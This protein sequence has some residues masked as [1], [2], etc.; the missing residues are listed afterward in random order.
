M[1]AN[2]IRVLGVDPASAGATGYA[3]IDG[4]GA[5]CAA[6]HYG[7]LPAARN[8]TNNMPARLRQIYTETASLIEK[9]Q[10][11]QVALEAIFAA[12][13]VRTALRLAEVRGV[14][15]LAAAQSNLP[16][17]SYS[18]RQVKATIAGYGHATKEQIQHMVRALLGLEEIPQPTHAA[19]AL[20][21]ALCHLRFAQMEA[22]FGAP[23]SALVPARSARPAA[24]IRI[25]A[26]AIRAAAI[27]STIS[28]RNTS[29][30]P[31][32]LSAR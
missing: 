32:V 21:V 30:A 13:N 23:P 4:C 15:L 5:R 12:L 25:S 17:H 6:V 11:D 16:V 8:A 22:K 1:P 27:P 14:I 24:A 26:T 28:K 2:V 10:P 29:R 31:R 9:Y 19:D 20:A 7:I 18:P 3:V